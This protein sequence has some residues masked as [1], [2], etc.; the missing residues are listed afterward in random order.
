M[1]ARASFPAE[2]ESA[3]A[4]RRFSE[5]ILEEWGRLDFCDTTRLLVSELVVNAVLHARSESTVVLELER[6]S[7]LRVEVTD[8]SAALPMQRDYAPSAPTGRGLM[9]V[10]ALAD[11]WGVDTDETGKTVWFELIADPSGDGAR[12]AGAA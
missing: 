5:E 6:Q 2:L 9:I 1:R 10:D 8:S 7:R 12:H 3:A 11:R 4:A